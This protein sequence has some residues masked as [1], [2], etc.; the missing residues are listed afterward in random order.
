MS[1]KMTAREISDGLWEYAPTMSPAWLIHEMG[2]VYV[3]YE[4]PQYGG[5]L[6]ASSKHD[7]LSDALKAAGNLC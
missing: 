2:G 5:E 1:I 7:R 6:Q 4:Y 3:L